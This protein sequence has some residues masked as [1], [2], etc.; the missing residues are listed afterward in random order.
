VNS[1][2]C[3]STGVWVNLMCASALSRNVESFKIIINVVD[4]IYFNNT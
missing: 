1:C 4:E 2:D 3:F